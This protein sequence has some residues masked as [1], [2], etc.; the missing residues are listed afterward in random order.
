MPTVISERKIRKLL[1]CLIM[2]LLLI[3]AAAL[4]LPL[5]GYAASAEAEESAEAEDITEQTPQAT[6]GQAQ[7]TEIVEGA[8]EGQ[9]I[10]GDPALEP[11]YTNDPIPE[12]PVNSEAGEALP[13][14]APF[15]AEANKAVIEPLLTTTETS[16][17]PQNAIQKA[18]DAA[19][20]NIEADTKEITITVDAGVYEGDIEISAKRSIPVTATTFYRDAE[21]TLLGSTQEQTADE[22]SYAIPSDFTLK[23]L[24]NDAG[25]TL[26]EAGDSVKVNG[27]VTISDV[28][29]IIAGL[30]FSINKLINVINEEK[31]EDGVSAQVYGTT[32]DDNIKLSAGNGTEVEVYGGDGG[33]SIAL[34]TGPGAA[35]ALDGGAGD[36]SIS[37]TSASPADSG[38]GAS[39]TVSGGDG[40]DVVT[41]DVS[42][43]NAASAAEV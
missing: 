9:S 11:V 26:L 20:Q 17:P 30:Y 27:N 41:A 7:I 36:D 32:G 38:G 34:D 15:D 13:E 16:T 31:G 1:L 24:A 37:V 6:Q 42:L 39:V 8:G 35:A 19:L 14:T 25:N 18:I 10:E 3:A 40:S 2:S 5:S 29:V 4:A 28:N 33:D 22:R 12:G 23:I 21:G 43:G